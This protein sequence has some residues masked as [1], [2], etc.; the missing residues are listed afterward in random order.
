M[1]LL[2]D[3]HFTPPGYGIFEHLL[4]LCKL[5]SSEWA[6]AGV[7]SRQRQACQTHPGTKPKH[8]D[9]QITEMSSCSAGK[10]PNPDPAKNH[11]HVPGQPVTQPD[12]S[13]RPES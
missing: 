2:H 13:R 9:L 6:Q 10:T 11:R 8:G 4:P 7:S 3:K 5:P 12:G 1:P